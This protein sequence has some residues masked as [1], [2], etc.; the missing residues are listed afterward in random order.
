MSEPNGFQQR[1]I[2]GRGDDSSL[3]SEPRRAE[4]EGEHPQS[5]RETRE[6]PPG[7]RAPNLSGAM[8]Q[9]QATARLRAHARPA[10][11]RRFTYGAK[12]KKRSSGVQ[13][14]RSVGGG[15]YSWVRGHQRRLGW[16]RFLV[17]VV[18]GLSG[19][20]VAYLAFLWLTL[21]SV[22][23]PKTFL[24]DESTI[25]T[26]RNGVE[27]DRLGDEDRTVIPTDQ[28]PKVMKQAMIA[29]E[30]E[31]F[32]TH[33][34]VEIRSIMRAVFARLIGRSVTGGASTLTQQLARNSLISSE[35][36]LT[37]KLR[38]VML[39]C[40]IERVYG[41]DDVLGLYL[42]WVPFGPNIYGIEQ[43]SKKYFAQ[44]AKDLTLGEAAVLASMPQRPPY[45]NPY[46][47]HVRTKVTEDIEE[48]IRAGKI[49]KR[50]QIPDNRITPGLLGNSFGTG[51]TVIY[52]G[53]RA[54][55][56]LRNMQDQKMI[57]NEQRLQ[58]LD[59]L[60]RLEFTPDRESIR[61]P[62]FTLWLRKNLEST[63]SQANDESLVQQSGLTIQTT[64]DW[65]LQQIAEKIIAQKREGIVKTYGAHNIALMAMDPRTREIL[66]YVGN[67]DY[68]DQEHGGKIDMVQEPRD[69]GS[70]FKPIIYA[71]AFTKGYGPATV[72]YDVKTKFGQNEP[73]NYEGGFWGL[74]NARRALA[75]SRNIPAIKAFFLAGGENE[76][77]VLD[78]A[79]KLGATSPKQ[80]KEKI[81]ATTDPHYDYGYTLAIGT[82]DTP[83]Y[84]MAN[85]YSTF[86]SGG[87]YKD[88]VSILK[89]TDRNKA[90]RFQSDLQ[91]PGDDVLDPRVAYEITSILSDVG[92]RPGGFW[93][94]ALS[95]PD[96]QAAAK[97]GTSNDC[98]VWNDAA[99][100]DCKVRK[101][102]DVWT[103]GYSPTLVTAV[104]VGNADSAPL[105]DRADGL[106]V[107]APIWKEFMTQALR[108]LKPA[109]K[110]FKMP[111]GIVQPQVSL[112]SGEL[113]TDCTP[114]DQRKPE[115]FLR[116][117]APT[118]PDPA[119]AT[120][121]V[122]RVTG[123]LASDNCPAEAREE[124]SFLVPHSILAERWPEWEKGVQAWAAGL[125]ESGTGF[126]LRVAPTEQCDI[127]KTPGRGIKPTLTVLYPTEGGI[128]GYP[129]FAPQID[130]RV[131]SGVLMVQYELDGKPLETATT[132][133]FAPTLRLPRSID[134][135]GTHQL[136]VTLT[137]SYYNQASQTV[138]IRFDEDRTSPQ[139]Q[140][141]IPLSGISIRQGSTLHM[142]ADASDDGGIRY[143]E[144]YLDDLLLARKPVAPYELSYPMKN[145]SPG[146]HSLRAVATDFGGNTS[147]ARVGVVVE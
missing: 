75:G 38:E 4:R 134:K 52:I 124:R 41:K 115:I 13:R 137:D 45:Y 139:V 135:E 2:S 8:Q 127:S 76:D 54:D 61:A 101:P 35:R 147:E 62:Y 100:G 96:Y 29:I 142:T 33:G 10:S 58:A 130:Y 109:E 89:V 34:C 103:I 105:T 42:N 17:R 31:R 70:S 136:K 111:D 60:A 80:L 104:W 87:Q 56:V 12:E 39:A 119:C 19:V 144:F 95:V 63:F 84:E 146:P 40:E 77:S 11:R 125:Q 114:I 28:I 50:S 47:A 113:P 132:A 26:D 71:D 117:N 59:E 110:T 129:A 43:A 145:A 57:T 9:S 68:S 120:L 86:A 30:D 20:F 69:P 64:L 143:V 79:A 27:L 112:L 21:P 140:F 81:R 1:P 46:G 91:K 16:R 97:T 15:A 82:G 22:R 99:T 3:P 44:S 49:T 121:T 107:A 118:K 66:A 7:R 83:V 108:A 128:A 116:E 23:D 6:T 65:R 92:A 106:N 94:S 122:D 138:N 78:F 102:R 5:E 55:Q 25:I 72:L 90:I 88:P 24:P 123:L 93:Q 36:T 73:Q 141:V 18:G 74:V 51:A 14:L 53:G 85:A 98:I 48:K 32:Y 126:A 37:R 131:G 67:S 133:P